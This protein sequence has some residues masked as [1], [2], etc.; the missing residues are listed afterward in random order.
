MEE[1]MKYGITINPTITEWENNDPHITTQLIIAYSKLLI[2]NKL[3]PYEY[4]PVLAWTYLNDDF[5]QNRITLVLTAEP[6]SNEI[7]V[8]NYKDR[9]K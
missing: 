3:S 6:V 2:D 8:G 4:H 5:A 9:L 7:T 1:K